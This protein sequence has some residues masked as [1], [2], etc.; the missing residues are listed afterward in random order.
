L[1]RTRQIDRSTVVIDAPRVT[2]RDGPVPANALRFC[3]EGGLEDA[4]LTP[5]S[6]FRPLALCPL[7]RIKSAALIRPGLLRRELRP[8]RLD[9]ACP[10]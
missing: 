10:F 2:A 3:D 4:P 5:R 7:A 1:R 6:G 8:L 9:A